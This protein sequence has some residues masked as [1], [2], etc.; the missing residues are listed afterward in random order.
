MEPLLPWIQFDEEKSGVFDD[1]RGI[2]TDANRVRFV[3][4]LTVSDGRV[5]EFVKEWNGST[6]DRGYLNWVD[7]AALASTYSLAPDFE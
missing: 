3:F 6:Y 2:H 5:E 1:Y 7:E 4:N